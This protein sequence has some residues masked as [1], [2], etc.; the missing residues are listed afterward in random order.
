MLLT[1]LLIIYPMFLLEGLKA[2]EEISS[3]PGI[4]RL[5]LERLLNE[6]DVNI[7]NGLKS[8]YIVQDTIHSVK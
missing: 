3:M 1:V 8:R 4:K 5:G 2:E 7:K 6:V